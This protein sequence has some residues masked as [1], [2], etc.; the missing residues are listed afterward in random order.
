MSDTVE[1]LPA[2]IGIWLGW[3][4]E[5]VETEGDIQYAGWAGYFDLERA[6]DLPEE[7]DDYEAAIVVAF[8]DG[9]MIV[10]AFESHGFA[11]LRWLSWW[12]SFRKSPEPDDRD[13]VF[14]LDDTANR[15]IVEPHFKVKD[16]EVMRKWLSK[17]IQTDPNY[18]GRKVWFYDHRIGNYYLWE[19]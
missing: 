11:G 14:T 12:D 2:E 10:E 17:K 19:L 13:I 5:A 7:L 3:N 9:T 15:F 18:F 6:E 16:Y 1:E 4:L 8:K